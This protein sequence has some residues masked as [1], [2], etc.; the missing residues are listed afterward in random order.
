MNDNIITVKIHPA[1]LKIRGDREIYKP[2][3]KQYKI[4][5][6]NATLPRQSGERDTL[7]VEKSAKSNV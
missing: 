6:K 3:N 7:L 1:V 2:I 5:T 4:R